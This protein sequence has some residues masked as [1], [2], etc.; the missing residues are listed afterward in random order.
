MGLNSLYW[1]AAARR[2][3]PE[4]ESLSD[5]DDREN[6]QSEMEGEVRDEMSAGTTMFLPNQFFRS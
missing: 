2:K 5:I 6:L 3:K 4:I 1:A